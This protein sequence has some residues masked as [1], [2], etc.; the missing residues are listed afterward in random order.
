MTK[1]KKVC[2]LVGVLLVI[3]GLGLFGFTVVQGATGFHSRL[4]SIGLD[5]DVWSFD[6]PDGFGGSYPAYVALPGQLHTASDAETVLLKEGAELE[7]V[8]GRLMPEGSALRGILDFVN[9]AGSIAP[10]GLT[11]ASLS[12]AQEIQDYVDAYYEI[13]GQYPVF[14]LKTV[15]SLVVSAEPAMVVADEADIPH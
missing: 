7:T 13:N 6:A 2:L 4:I 8:Y 10:D 1:K 3:A 11:Q 12:T 15:N 5:E 9:E 14:L